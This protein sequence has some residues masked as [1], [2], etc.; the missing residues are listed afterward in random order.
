MTVQK[1]R[2]GWPRLPP[3]PHLQVQ[4]LHNHSLLQLAVG[5]LQKMTAEWG[6]KCTADLM[7]R[8]VSKEMGHGVPGEG[9]R[10]CLAHEFKEKRKPFQSGDVSLSQVLEHLG[11]GIRWDSLWRRLVLQNIQ[12]NV[13]F[14]HFKMIHGLW[15]R[16]GLKFKAEVYSLLLLEEGLSGCKVSLEGSS[17]LDIW[18]VDKKK[19]KV[20][21]SVDK[22]VFASQLP[23]WYLCWHI[24]SIKRVLRCTANSILSQFNPIY[25]DNVL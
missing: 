5:H 12:W 14:A 15:F 22:A 10:I 6:E 19:I 7:S 4:A 13:L 9:W 1:Q 18:N 21:A 23:I 17:N 16:V 11:L 2:L 20:L 25:P 3:N 24:P 8:Y